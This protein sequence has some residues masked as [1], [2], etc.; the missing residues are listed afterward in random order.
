M[1]DVTDPSRSAPRVWA[2]WLAPLAVVATVALTAWQQSRV[3][4]RDDWKAATDA[5]RAA[6]APGDGVSWMPYHAGEGRL[7]FHGLPAFH[8]PEADRG[9]A[10]LARYERVWLLGAFGYDADDLEGPIRRLDRQTFGALTLDLVRATGPRVV[11]D[12]YADLD[13]ARLRRVYENKPEQTCD[14]WSGRGW[15]CNLKRSPDATRRCLGQSVAKRHAKRQRRGECHLYDCSV[16]DC[17]LD[18]W[19]HASR[20]VHVIGDGVR[21]CIWL[22]PMREATVVLDW[23]DAPTGDTLVT[24]YGFVDKIVAD[25]YRRHIKVKPARLSVYRGDARIGELEVDNVKG[26]FRHEVELADDAAP[27]R[28]E[29]TT[30][31]TRDA[32]FCFDPTIR[33]ERQ[34]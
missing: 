20:D 23:P 1:T 28:F 12:L 11:G 14:F 9:V 29:L 24:D 25:N 34:P 5:I 7:F 33:A 22:H 18:P 19:L 15:H 8:L 21:R 4:T 16:R 13:R 26:W 31:S 32:Y 3:P 30:E 17:G 27:I 10:D 2:W 6:L